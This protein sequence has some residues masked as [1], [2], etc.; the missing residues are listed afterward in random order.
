MV[1]PKLVRDAGG[2]VLVDQGAGDEPV[3]AERRDVL[4]QLV[5]GDGVGQAPA[6]APA[7]P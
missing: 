6:R 1:T 4:V 2:A 3:Q 7:W 5:I